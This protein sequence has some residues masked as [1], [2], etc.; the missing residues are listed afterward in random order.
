MRSRSGPTG[1]RRRSSSDGAQAKSPLGPGSSVTFDGP[2]AQ[3]QAALYEKNDQSPD[4]SE[5]S[6]GLTVLAPASVHVP[7]GLT[8]RISPAGSPATPGTSVRPNWAYSNGTSSTPVPP[9]ASVIAAGMTGGRSLPKK[10]V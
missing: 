7:P 5:P 1:H 2:S 10:A 4:S 6:D 9:G 3:P 8:A